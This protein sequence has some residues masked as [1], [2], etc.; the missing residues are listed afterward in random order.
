[1]ETSNFGR[2]ITVS[3]FKTLFSTATVNIVETST[4]A[5]AV[6]N[7]AGQY[8]GA[9]SK[10]Y[11]VGGDTPM[12]VELLGKDTPTWCLYNHKQQGKVLETL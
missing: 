7:S 2:R 11:I 4:G 8:I 10:D 12:F 3:E 6:A 9:V 5:R 1:M